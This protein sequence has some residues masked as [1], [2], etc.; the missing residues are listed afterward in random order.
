MWWRRRENVEDTAA[1]VVPAADAGDDDGWMLDWRRV[2]RRHE[3]SRPDRGSRVVRPLPTSTT[4]F[5]RAGG[6]TELPRPP[7][8][9]P[10]TANNAPTPLRPVASAAE[11]ERTAGSHSYRDDG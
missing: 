3:A 2:R 5:R 8:R 10:W 7:R 6:T 4:G 11:A 9:R 1:V